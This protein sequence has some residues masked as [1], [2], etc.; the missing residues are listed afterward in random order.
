MSKKIYSVIK[1][2]G[3]FLPKN[4]IKNSDFLDSQFYNPD[5]SKIETPNEE[6]IEKFLEIT[7]IEERRYLDDDMQTSD[8]AY[9]AAKDALDSSKIDPETL[10][11]IIVAHN[12]GDVKKDSYRTDMMP[13]LAA[14]VKQKLKIKNSDCIAYDIPFGC[15]GWIQGM[16]MADYYIKSGDAKRILVIGADALSRMVDPHG[17]DSMIFA[18][19]AG[20]TILEA[21]ESEEP[22]GIIA[23]KTI[24]D[25]LVEADY[26]V[27]QPS[28]NKDFDQNNILIKMNGRRIYEY[29]VVKVPQIM[30]TALDKVNLTAED[31]KMVLIHQANAK[32]DYAMGKRFMKLYGINKMPEKLM[33]MTLAKFGNSSVATIPTMYDLIINGKKEGYSIDKGDVLVF[34]SVGAGLNANVLVYKVPAE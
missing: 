20:A 8:M 17:R 23:H 33:P 7:E 22:V 9:F 16:I 27:N 19:G 10:D 25:T 34:P 13:T 15:P 2:S 29:A 12:F 5:G 28:F 30:K 4:I 14:R 3:H 18:D 11:Y 26:L 32:M 31:V 21:V 1:G 6:I 24:S